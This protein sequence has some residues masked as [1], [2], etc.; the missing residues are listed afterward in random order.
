MLG[1]LL[2]LKF[3]DVPI[4]NLVSENPRRV[5]L[6]K[7]VTNVNPELVK[8]GELQAHRRVFGFIGVGQASRPSP[9]PADLNDPKPSTSSGSFL[10]VDADHGSDTS[11]VRSFESIGGD[12]STPRR[13]TKEPKAQLAAV[14]E[15]F[16][17]FKV[18]RRES[19]QST[20]A[21][22]LG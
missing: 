6:A 21:V 19:L 13:P 15:Q 20:N 10:T 9:P 16:E 11:S 7:F 5:I 8:F 2:A 14:K 18:R 17:T 12:S 1:K 4:S 22:Y 3:V